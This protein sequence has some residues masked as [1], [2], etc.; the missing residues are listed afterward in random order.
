[1][2]VSGAPGVGKTSLVDE[3]RSIVTASD[4]W[5]VSGKFDQY[6]RDQ[7]F[8]GVHQAFRALGRLLLAEPEEELADVR[9]RLLRSLGP[10]AGLATAVVPEFAAL[11]K[12]PPDP[13]DPMT[14]QVRAQRDAVEILRAVASRKRPVVFVVDDLQWAARTPLGLVDMVLSGYEQVDGLLLVGVLPR[15]RRRR[16][17]PTGTDVVSLAADNA[18]GRCICGWTTSPRRAWPP[19]W[20]TCCTCPR[21]GPPISRTAIAPH[22]GCNPVRDGGVA[23][24]VAARRRADAGRR[25][26]AVGGEAALRQLGRADTAELLAKRAEA[27]PPKTR[28]LLGLVACLGGRVEL[29]VVN[30]ATGLPA[31]VVEQRLAPALDQGLLVLE[32]GSQQAVRF[33]HDRVQEGLLQH[34]GAQRQRIVRLR[35]A[36][37]LRRRPELFAVTAEQ[38]L[39]VVDAV[40]DPHERR[41]VAGAVAP[42]RRAGDAV[43]QPSAGGEALGG[44]GGAYRSGGHRHADR[45]ADRSTGCALQSRTAGRGRRALPRNRPDVHPPGTAHGRDPRTNEQPDQPGPSCGGGPARIGAAAPAWA[46]RTGAGAA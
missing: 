14:A 2:L 8:D 23:Q 38:Y 3:L 27:M 44:G 33:R 13:G 36:R 1:M 43:K 4:G 11:L 12:V 21:S 18:P 17:A 25:Q 7:E 20:R 24:R 41:L 19:W 22:T 26:S 34:L 29:N 46:R 30:D 5:F 28:A 32:P 10:N 39:P 35:M 16:H 15:G 40:S 37:R 31:S 9:E 42:R 6:R 45:A